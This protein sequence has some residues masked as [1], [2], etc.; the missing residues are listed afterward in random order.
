MAKRKVTDD[1]LQKLGLT[2]EQCELAKPLTRLELVTA[3][4]VDLE[5]LT[6]RQA[7]I[8]AG[9]TAKTPG[10]QDVA[11]TKILK[12]DKV[13]AFRSS[14]VKQMLT[15]GMM[16]KEEAAK[17]L[18]NIAKSKITDLIEFK[19]IEVGEDENGSPVYQAVW[20]VKDCENLTDNAAALIKS[21]TA[22]KQ[23][24]KI[25]FHDQMSAIKQLGEMFGWNAPKKHEHSG[26]FKHTH[27]EKTDEELEAR[28]AELE[29]QVN[30]ADD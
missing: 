30:K 7:Y 17:K 29:E 25:E 9:G 20:S 19:N 26:E 18:S 3:I 14:L 15:D 21:V 24:P 1:Y 23:G 2:E 5:G 11:A 8:K 6:G 13:E 12:K 28:I 10:S 4:G 27:E 16:T 22:T